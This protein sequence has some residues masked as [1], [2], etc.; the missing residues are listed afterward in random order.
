MQCKD[1][2]DAVLEYRKAAALD[3][4]NSDLHSY[5]LNAITESGDWTAAAEEDF[6]LSDSLMRQLPKKIGGFFHSN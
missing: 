6:H 4:E 1:Y 5:L 3:P 2:K